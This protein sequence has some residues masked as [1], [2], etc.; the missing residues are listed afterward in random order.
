MYYGKKLFRQVEQSTTPLT[1]AFITATGIT[2]TTIINALETFEGSL[3]S[4]SL[5]SKMIAIYPFVGG[6]AATHKYNFMDARDLDAAFRVDFNGTWT[7]NS[8]GARN[9]STGYADTHLVPNT[10]ATS[11]H[12]SK[13]TTDNSNTGTDEIDIG[14][15]DASSNLWLSLWYNKSGFSNNLLARHASNTVLLDGGVV[16]DS[17]GMG[18]VSKV[19]TTAQLYK[20]GTSLDSK[21]DTAGLPTTSIYFGCYNQTG[22]PRLYSDRIN[23]F[24][25]IGDG[26]TSTEVSNLYTIVQQLQTDLSRNV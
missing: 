20:N 14:A 4:N 24:I 8:N 18:C 11:I 6:T 2:S 3:N 23:T 9:V 16:T 12:L 5:T 17:Q 15:R 1:D 13:Y 25:S 21:T 19:G 10:E 7:H 26:L 22:S